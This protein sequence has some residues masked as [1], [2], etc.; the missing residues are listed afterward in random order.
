MK[1]FFISLIALLII[2][3][4]CSAKVDIFKVPDTISVNDYSVVMNEETKSY[5]RGCNDAL[6]ASAQSRV[7]FVTVPTTGEEATDEYAKRLYNT[8]GVKNI[9]NGTSTFVLLATDDMQYW[10]IVGDNLKSALT[11]DIVNKFLL[12]NMEPDFAA[13]NFD[14]AIRKTFNA[15]NSWY[16]STFHSSTTA[17]QND[18]A[19]NAKK[20]NGLKMLGTVLKVILLVIVLFIVGLILFAYVKR[21]IRLR[22]IAR[23][24]K[25]RRAQKFSYLEDKKSDDVNV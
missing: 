12:E 4:M 19:N 25:S 15:F 20:G 3:I 8:W 14:S 5:I 23:R 6:M 2:P 21:E 24:R 9:G 1:K 18:Q 16:T 22:Q 11:T 10:V 13:R 7:I 17:N